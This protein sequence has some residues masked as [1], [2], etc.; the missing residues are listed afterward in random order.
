MVIWVLG[1]SM[2]VLSGLIFLPKS[3]IL[4][5]SL[6]LIFGHN[7]LDNIKLEGNFIWAIIHEGGFMQ[8]AGKDFAIVYPLVPWVGLM[9]LGYVIGNWYL[10]DY[11]N[12]ERR[13]NLIL[14]GVLSIM[15]FILLR[16]IHGYG[17]PEEWH[18]W[19]SRRQYLI[20]FFSPSKYPPSLHF[21]LMTIGP[22]CIFLALS[23]NLWGKWVEKISVFGRVPFFYYVIHLFFIHALAMLASELTGYG[24][25]RQIQSD[26]KSYHDGL[27]GFGF[28]LVGVYFVWI[29]VVI[30][31]YPFSRWFDA[32]KRR[33]KRK[34]WLSYL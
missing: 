34:K 7:L 11:L 29:F 13:K 6:V 30:S 21:L 20:E 19:E 9:S 2:V 8:F 22:L 32:Y 17:D 10:P 3:V 24:W 14:M 25:E 18:Q 5:F 31:L 27:K 15:G 16:S 1:L 26:W 12:S 33:N 4:T 28:P 23:E